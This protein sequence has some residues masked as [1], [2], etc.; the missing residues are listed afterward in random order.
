[1]LYWLAVNGSANSTETA[2][3]RVF[4]SYAQDSERHNEQVRIMSTLLRR[5]YG[6][7]AHLDKW[8][9]NER[10]DWTRF[11]IEQIEQANFVLAVASPAFR[12]RADGSGDGTHG[13]GARF[14]GS[15]LRNKMMQNQAEWLPRILP[16]VLPGC[17]IEDIPEFLLPFSASHY[18]VEEVTVAGLT[19]IA[20]VLAGQARF[21]MPERGEYRAGPFSAAGPEPAPP[22]RSRRPGD[23]AGKYSTT[24]V[25]SKIGR[26]HQGDRYY[27]QDD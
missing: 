2:S 7:N 22:Q 14:E 11:A 24:F 17:S 4:V 12:E 19:D 5:D 10:R 25:N 1:V 8:Y 16:V 26:V 3:P 15:V 20:A 23:D 9:E 27:F 13:R 21:P 18:R 6:L